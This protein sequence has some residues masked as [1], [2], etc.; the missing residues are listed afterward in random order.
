VAEDLGEKSEP[1]TDHQK[2]KLR[3]SGQIPRST[4]LG[5]ALGLAGAVIAILF[6]APIMLDGWRLTFYE[7]LSG[8]LTDDIFSERAAQHHFAVALWSAVKIGAP[9][10]IAM[11]LVSILANIWQVGFLFTLEPMQPKLSK[12]NPISGV[13]RFFSIKTAM[14]AF[15]NIGKV[16][17]ILIVAVSVISRHIDEILMLSR[18]EFAQ[19][20]VMAAHLFIELA[21]WLVAVLIL[22]GVIDY[23]YQ[24]WQWERDNRM[25]KHAVKEEMRNMVGDPTMRKRRRDFAQKILNQRMRQAVPHADVVVTNPE[26]LAL[27]LQWDPK[28]MN[29]PRVVAKGADFMAMQI[30]QIA[31]LH[32]V[33]IVERKPLAR[34][35]YPLVRVGDEIPPQF[36]QAIAEILTYVYQLTG[37]KAG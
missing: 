10:L 11:F 32:N 35:M 21:F 22:L 15:S 9:F 3:E 5:G 28:T 31:A 26:H 17:L 33:P 14:R 12:L 34:A 18:F 8:G 25:S 20:V 27:A 1:A 6:L 24:K 29:A 2:R 7:F 13:K 4:D 16:V 30:R 37:K 23:V 19:A 36:Y